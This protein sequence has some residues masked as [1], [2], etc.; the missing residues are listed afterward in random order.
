MEKTF[1]I[2]V[3]VLRRVRSYLKKTQLRNEETEESIHG[4]ERHFLGYQKERD[5]PF[6]TLN[7]LEKKEG[8]RD[9]QCP[10][11]A[12]CGASIRRGL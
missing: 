2:H 3:Q 9:R 1:K 10:L 8:A 11:Q 12:F 5:L 4:M 6:Q 7:L